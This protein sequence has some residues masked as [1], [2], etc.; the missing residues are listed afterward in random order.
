[1]LAL[2]TTSW[3]LEPRVA[4]NAFCTGVKPVY[5]LTTRLG[6]SIRATGNHKFLAFEGWRRLD[7]MAA[8]M[9]LAVPRQLAGPNGSDMGEA[10]L[11]LLGDLIGDGRTLPRH[12]IQYTSQY[13][14][15][16]IDLPH[17]GAATATEVSTLYKSAMSRERAARVA[18]A[19][20]SESLSALA[21]SDVY[22]DEVVSIEA[23]GS[24]EVF[25]LTVEGLH[26]FVAEDVIVHNSIEQD[27]DLVMFLY[28]DEYYNEQSD[29][30]G[31]AEIILAKHRNGPIGTE[32]LAFLKRFAKFADLAPQHDARAAA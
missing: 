11:A 3:R 22:W 21:E 20:G 1:M 23:D 17:A 26:N 9:R 30:Q 7:D 18:R 16:D 14:S 10:E 6:Y 19:V 13:T 15:R 25:D 12:A 27:A 8:G 5:R 28:R 24:E 31:L 2:D 4:T 29:D 32:K